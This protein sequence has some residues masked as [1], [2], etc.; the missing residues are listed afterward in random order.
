MIHLKPSYKNLHMIQ[1]QR[2]LHNIQLQFNLNTVIEGEPT[3]TD[4]IVQHT[5]AIIEEKLAYKNLHMI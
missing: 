2:K 4:A 5:T 1:L 3:E